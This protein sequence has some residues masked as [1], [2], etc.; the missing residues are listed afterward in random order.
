MKILAV[1]P[2]RYQSSR[3]PGKPL[4][5]IFGKSMIQRVYE[6]V[7]AANGIDKCVVATDDKRIEKHC[8]DL[9]L[10][11]IMT[12][13]KHSCGTERCAEVAAKLSGYDFVFNI[14]GDE[15]FLATEVL[16]QTTKQL[17]KSIEI[18]SLYKLSTSEME[19]HN[20]SVIKVVLSDEQNALYFS[21]APIPFFREGNFTSFN[22][23]IGLY[24]YKSDVLQKI[25]SLPESSLEKT[26]MLEQL[27]WLANGY[28]IKMFATAHESNSVDTPEDYKQLLV[29]YSHL[30]K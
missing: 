22:K 9:G 5:D 3:F 20:A 26:E 21:R 18:A 10:E 13:E 2:A 6:N 19:F 25:V 17:D 4:I 15:P 8:L 14:Q 29:K 1:I 27:R 7:Q 12:S 11:V 30:Q 23:H 24:I 16:E 28:S